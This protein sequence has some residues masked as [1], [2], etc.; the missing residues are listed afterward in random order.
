VT[1]GEYPLLY[2]FLFLLHLVMAAGTDMFL[3]SKSLDM[4]L[5]MRSVRQCSLLI[6]D[7]PHRLLEVEL[8][9]AVK[10][11]VPSIMEKPQSKV[12]STI[13]ANREYWIDTTRYMSCN[14]H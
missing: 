1:T 6:H 5:C 13:M 7:L 10:A 2:V 4:S 11:P 14:Y 8:F 12:L 9:V 3:P